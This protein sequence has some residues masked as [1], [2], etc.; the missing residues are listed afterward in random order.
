MH[1]YPERL[2]HLEVPIPANDPRSG[3]TSRYSGLMQVIKDA[4]GEW[5]CCADLSLIAGR[6]T[7]QKSVALYSAAARRGLRIR[8][9]IQNGLLYVRLIGPT[10]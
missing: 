9:T 10:H 1:I 5:V 8:T 2:A 4:A 7:K 3:N 6:D